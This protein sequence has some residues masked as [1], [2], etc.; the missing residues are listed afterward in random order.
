MITVTYAEVQSYFRRLI[1]RAQRERAAYWYIRYRQQVAA[2]I[3]GS[4]STLSDADVN[5]LVHELR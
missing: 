3:V 1:F 5:Q 4:A 2:Q